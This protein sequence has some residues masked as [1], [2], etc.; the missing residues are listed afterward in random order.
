MRA[1]LADT[2]T[3]AAPA[4]SDAIRDAILRGEFVPNQRLVESDLADQ[5]GASRSAVR[6]AL[7]EL[8]NEGLIERVRNRG[9]RVRAVSLDEAVEICDVRLMLEP[10]CASLAATRADASERF[11]LHALGEAM[12]TAVDDVDLAGQSELNH[13]LHTLV[14]KLSAHHT[15]THILERLRAQ[16]VLHRFR[17]TTRPGRARESLT[18]HLAIISAICDG[19][20]DRAAD[21]TRRHLRAVLSALQQTTESPAGEA[22]ELT[23]RE[24]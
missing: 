5:F 13:Q 3:A 4:I 14:R 24:N 15:A 1:D 8:M 21:A 10:L 2:G 23:G 17:L 6:L 9:A 18:E 16:S 20:P 12:R 11:R 7:L 19:D 22:R